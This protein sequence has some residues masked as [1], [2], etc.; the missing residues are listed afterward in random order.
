MIAAEGQSLGCGRVL[1]DEK[2]PEERREGEVGGKE[3]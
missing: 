2:R 3:G 1:R